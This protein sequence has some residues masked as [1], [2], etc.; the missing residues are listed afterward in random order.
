MVNKQDWQTRILMLFIFSQL[1]RGTVGGDQAPEVLT[2]PWSKMVGHQ[3][4]R[5][6]EEDCKVEAGV[7]APR[8]PGQSRRKAWL[9]LEVRW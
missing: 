2:A 1:N 9:D 5:K 3:E 8:E 6:A 7:V 4:E